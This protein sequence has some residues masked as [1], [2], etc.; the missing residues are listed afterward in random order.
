MPATHEQPA[1]HVTE[2][3]RAARK[4]GADLA[5]ADPRRWALLMR[6]E[7]HLRAQ[8]VEPDEAARVAWEHVC[9]MIA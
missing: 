8:G 9:G 6:V 4:R 7:D 3:W 1:A 2:Q 5:R